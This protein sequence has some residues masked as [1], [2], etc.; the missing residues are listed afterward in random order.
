MNIIKVQCII[1]RV[2]NKS[3]CKTKSHY[4]ISIQ[5]AQN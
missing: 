4:S 5:A 1:T 2:F 3:N